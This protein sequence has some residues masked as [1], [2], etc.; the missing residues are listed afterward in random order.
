ML[1]LPIADLVGLVI[2]VFPGM[3][4]RYVRTI[5]EESNL[6]SSTVYSPD[7]ESR[8][9]TLGH[10]LLARRQHQGNFAPKV[11]CGKRQYCSSKRTS[12]NDNDRRTTCS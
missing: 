5:G 9:A 10:D 8:Q 4:Y 6:R 3:Y 2:V 7:F 12:K 1:V 11:L